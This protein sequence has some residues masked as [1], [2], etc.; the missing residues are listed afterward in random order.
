MTP[1][2]GRLLEQMDQLTEMVVAAT[3]AEMRV[4]ACAIARQARDVHPEV[5]HVHLTASDQGDWLD[6]TGWDDGEDV[7]EDLDLPDEVAAAASHLYVPHIG[8]HGQEGAVP[9]LWVTDR[10]RGTFI[11]DVHQVLD[12]CESRRTAAAEVLLTRDP[13]GPTAVDVAIFGVLVAAADTQ[14]FSIDAG[15]GW[16][17]TDWVEHRDT[18]LRLVSPSLQEPLRAALADPPGGKYVEGRAGRNWLG[19]T[20]PAN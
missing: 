17:W 18:T 5:L 14:T 2:V 1:V 3:V 4:A 15:A 20:R 6:V 7:E 12:E 13:D 16:E 19:G 9:G 10:R 11:L 8:R